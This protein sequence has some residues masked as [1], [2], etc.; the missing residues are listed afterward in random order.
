MLTRDECFLYKYFIDKYQPYLYP[1]L[2]ARVARM[3]GRRGGR[4]ID[5]GTGPGCL[6]AQLVERTGAEVHAVDINP[7]MHE[8]AR[9]HCHERGVAGNVHFDLAD[10]HALQYPDRFADLIVSYSCLHHWANPTQALREC[11]R[12]LADG[13][14]LLIVDTHPSAHA[15][16]DALRRAIVEPEMFR[17][18]RE[19]IEESLLPGD[20]ERMARAAGLRGFTLQTFDFEELDFIE[21]LEQLE[22]TS[23]SFLQ[24]DLP[25]AATM[26]WLLSLTRERGV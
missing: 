24:E 16:L 23:T 7:A 13:G 3:Y 9:A 21:C 25:Q 4:I 14:Q 17:F 1:L 8:L 19:A 11:Y 10:I 5:M 2:G 18:V 20:V 22:S 12:V 6:A 15:A 26:S